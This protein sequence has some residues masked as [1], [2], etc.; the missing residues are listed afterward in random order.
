MTRSSIPDLP[1]WVKLVYLAEGA[2]NV[3]YRFVSTDITP[4]PDQS[5]PSAPTGD[6]ADLHSLKGKLLRLRKDTPA[7]VPYREIAQNFDTVI[8]PLFD[9]HELVDQSLVRLPLGLIHHCNER[10]RLAE[11]TGARAQKRHGSY[12][13]LTEPFGLLV[14][15]MTTDHH[16]DSNLAELKPKWLLQSPSAPQDARRCR[17]CALRGMRNIEARRQ[18]QK[19][20]RSFCP[21][22]LVSENYGDVFAATADIKGCPDRTRLAKIL[23]RHPLLVKLL[24]HQKAHQRVGLNGPLGLTQEMSLDMTLRD[25]TVY[26]KVG[27]NIQD[28]PE[29]EETEKHLLNEE[30][31]DHAGF[32]DRFS[33]RRSRLKVQCRRQSS[34]LA[35]SRNP[36]NRWRMV[37]RA[38]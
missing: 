36:T 28:A 2:A 15:D 30:K 34:I 31:Q 35:R 4:D 6:C 26:I 3:V 14:T 1:S 27:D 18:G 37:P 32:G 29:R 22:N 21:L 13:S 23:F 12:L 5:T 9:P 11:E 25:C 38:E 20:P 10:L 17:T 7:N 33:P 19:E 16:P 24:A 8:R